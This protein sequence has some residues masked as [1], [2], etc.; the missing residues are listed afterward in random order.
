MFEISASDEI[1][2]LA[3]PTETQVKRYFILEKKLKEKY[4]NVNFCHTNGSK[5]NYKLYDSR[6]EYKT[7]NFVKNELSKNENDLK[8][9]IKKRYERCISIE[10]QIT[11]KKEHMS[12]QSRKSINNTIY[13]ISKECSLMTKKY[14]KSLKSDDEISLLSSIDS[15]R[16]AKSAVS[17]GSYIMEFTDFCFYKSQFLDIVSSVVIDNLKQKSKFTKKFLEMD[18][19]MFCEK[20]EITQLEL[21]EYKLLIDYLEKELK[22]EFENELFKRQMFYRMK[23][24]FL[25][26]AVNFYKAKIKVLPSGVT[27]YYSNVKGNYKLFANIAEN[28]LLFKRF[29]EMGNFLIDIEEFISNIK[30][31]ACDINAILDIYENFD[32]LLEVHIKVQKYDDYRDY[33]ISRFTKLTNNQREELNNRCLKEHNYAIALVVKKFLEDYTDI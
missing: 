15:E 4:K 9:N 31:F 5:M 20:L 2:Q 25:L 13:S 28:M 19:N 33:L 21:I 24:S 18:F 3:K 6:N 27:S 29:F 32:D 22:P 10:N 11:E 26:F 17:R 16:N 30:V 1:K 14:K 12:Y 8:I 7:F 23:S